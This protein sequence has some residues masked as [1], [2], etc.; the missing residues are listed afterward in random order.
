MADIVIQLLP[1][2]LAALTYAALGFHFWNTR[3]REHDGQCV[4]CPMQ[5]WERGV[6]AVALLLHVY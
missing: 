4:A 2:I 1:H 6:I 5:T 3:W